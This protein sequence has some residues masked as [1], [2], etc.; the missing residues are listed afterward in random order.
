MVGIRIAAVLGGFFLLY[1]VY[2]TMKSVARCSKQGTEDGNEDE[3]SEEE[4]EED[5]K[6][7]EELEVVVESSRLDWELASAMRGADDTV[8]GLRS[9]MRSVS[10]PLSQYLGR[11]QCSVELPVC[12][13]DRT[14]DRTDSRTCA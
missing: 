1:A 13:E 14:C 8:H 4:E 2:N 7:A 5:G 3:T 6:Q 9:E 10:Y 12:D 11:L